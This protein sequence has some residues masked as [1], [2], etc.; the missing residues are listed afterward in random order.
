MESRAAS[1][2]E[3]AGNRANIVLGAMPY[4]TPFARLD[5]LRSAGITGLRRPMAASRCRPSGAEQVK[6][7]RRRIGHKVFPAARL[8]QAA[9]RRFAQPFE[10]SQIPS[11]QFHDHPS[12]MI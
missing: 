10:C 6:P 5:K 7:G 8:A 4:A 9:F 12:R 1:S 2:A 3:R 11:V